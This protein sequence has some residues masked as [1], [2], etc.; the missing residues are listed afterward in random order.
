MIEINN[1]LPKNLFL[2]LKGFL[3][4]DL[5]P[6]YYA[7]NSA[8]GSGPLTE[9]NKKY[10]Y[11][12][13]F[14]YA[15][16]VNGKPNS[17]QSPLFEACVLSALDKAQVEITNLIRIRVGLILGSPSPVVHGPHVDFQYPH[18]TA[19]LYMTTCDGDTLIYNEKIDFES[20]EDIFVQMEKINNQF[21]IKDTIKSEENKLVVFDGAHFHSSSNPSDTSSR[22]VLTI[23][24][25]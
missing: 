1:V 6:W 9:D 4:S 16:F 2:K 8:Y 13:S 21:T 18:K 10:L 24:F 20:K 15:P 25:D 19:L 17:S 23:N 5:C 12:S 7:D 3:Y 14:A 22:I 11:H